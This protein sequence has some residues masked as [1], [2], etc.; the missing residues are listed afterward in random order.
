LRGVGDISFVAPYVD[1]LSALGAR[2]S[3]FHAPGEL[4]DLESLSLQSKR[5]AILIS[6]LIQASSN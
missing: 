5:S 6:R 3:G 4:V 1:S 2:G